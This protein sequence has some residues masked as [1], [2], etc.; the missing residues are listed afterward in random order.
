[1]K[2]REITRLL[3]KGMELEPSNFSEPNLET[4]SLEVASERVN[5][6]DSVTVL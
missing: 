6:G 4:V 1:M 2:W 3:T 5:S